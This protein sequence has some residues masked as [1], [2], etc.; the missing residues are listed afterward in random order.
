MV[1]QPVPQ[2]PGGAH[3]VLVVVGDRGEVGLVAVGHEVLVLD[4]RAGALVD[5]V[6]AL[7]VGEPFQALQAVGLGADL[8][9]R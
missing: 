3:V 4:D 1:D 7:E 5:V 9:S 2:R 8:N 6:A